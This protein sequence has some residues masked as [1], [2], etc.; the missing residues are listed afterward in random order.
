MTDKENLNAKNQLDDANKPEFKKIMAKIPA[1]LMTRDQASSL[2]LKE[3]PYLIIIPKNILSQ[4][5][6]TVDLL[7]FDLIYCNKSLSLVCKTDTRLATDIL[8]DE[9]ST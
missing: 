1:S 9:V 5:G 8:L 3:E 7:S 4:I 2:N 6:I